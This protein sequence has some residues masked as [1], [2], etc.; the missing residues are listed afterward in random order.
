MLYMG[1]LIDAL[2]VI[3]VVLGPLVAFMAVLLV[4]GRE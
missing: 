1:T 2:I 3:G 4:L